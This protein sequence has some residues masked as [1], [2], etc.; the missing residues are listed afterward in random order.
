MMSGR[1]GW[2]LAFTLIELL[3]VIAIIAILA[4]ML[5]PALAA[6]REKARRSSCMNNLKQM[7]VGLESYTGDYSG[8]LPFNVTWALEQ[9]VNTYYYAWGNY[10][11]YPTTYHAPDPLSRG[12]FNVGAYRDPKG[13]V[14]HQGVN[15]YPAYTRPSSGYYSPKAQLGGGRFNYRIVAQGQLDRTS[16]DPYPSYQIGNLAM[17]PQGL[18]FLASGGYLA[19]L[20]AFYCPSASHMPDSS[21]Q[22]LHQSG[23]SDADNSISERPSGYTLGATDLSEIRMAG[24][25]DARLLT[26]G[27]WSKAGQILVNF[28]NDGRVRPIIYGRRVYSTYYYRSGAGIWWE[29]DRAAYIDPE[30]PQSEYIRG[31]TVRLPWTKPEIWHESQGPAFKTRKQLGGRAIVSDAFGRPSAKEYACDN[32]GQPGLSWWHHRD[33]YNVLYGDFS[34]KWYG[35][36]NQRIMWWPQAV[37]DCYYATNAACNYPTDSS[38]PGYKTDSATGDVYGGPSLDIWH[39]M[40]V[41][42]GV[43]VDSIRGR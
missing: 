8:Y 30:Y 31:T 32:T 10:S 13:A 11:S 21:Y 6:A 37:T 25:T 17:A 16:S 23:M 24:G 35:D 4:G 40:D 5:L 20:A 12:A 19:D 33:G 43:D 2:R 28:H 26:H 29:Y 22:S 27:D 3:V 1:L 38:A 34:S 39:S 7:G 18:G 36:P 42:A 9:D 15:A 14:P 41:A